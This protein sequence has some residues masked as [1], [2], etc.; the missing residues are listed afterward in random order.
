[1]KTYRSPRNV[2]AEVERL[3]ASAK[4]SFHRPSALAQVVALLCSTRHYSS[5]G[6]YLAV[7]DRVALRASSGLRLQRETVALGTDYVG[8]AAQ[9]GALV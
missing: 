9:T 4:P 7:G 2:I 6:I 8:S 3:I 1:M 5:A